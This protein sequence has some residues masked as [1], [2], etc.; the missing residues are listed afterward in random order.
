M[1]QICRIRRDCVQ[2]AVRGKVILQ[3]AGDA[4]VNDKPR[5]LIAPSWQADNIMELCISDMV[6]V[7]LGKGYYIVIRPHPQFIRMFPEHIAAFKERYSEYLSSEEIKL[8]LVF[9]D[10]KSVFLSDVVITDWSNIAF[11]FSYCTLKPCIFINTPMKVMNPNYKQY[12]LEVLDFSLRDKVGV[13]IDVDNIKGL[14]E[15]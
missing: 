6:E 10:N 11:E 2:F 14:D 13:S 1:A 5:L 9:S 12:G 4:F 3:I 8:E 15:A 7:L